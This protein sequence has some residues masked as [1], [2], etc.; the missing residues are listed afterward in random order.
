MLGSR[1]CQARTTEPE[2]SVTHIQYS[3]VDTILQVK[4]AAGGS[5]LAKRNDMCNDTDSRQLHTFQRHFK[6][7]LITKG[8]N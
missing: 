5:T 6:Y 7:D 2:Q 8:W 4:K 1:L 3:R